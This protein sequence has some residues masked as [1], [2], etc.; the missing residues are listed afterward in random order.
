MKSE[1]S[2][3]TLTHAESG[4]GGGGKRLGDV[5]AAD[6]P[7]GR[8]PHPAAVREALVRIVCE[9]GELGVTEIQAGAAV[10]SVYLRW[11]TPSMLTSTVSSCSGFLNAGTSS[12]S[13][14]RR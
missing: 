14:Q 8:L 2:K 12:E 5:T 11:K 10:A 6:E 9:A 3:D 7:W 4:Q 13:F 1:T